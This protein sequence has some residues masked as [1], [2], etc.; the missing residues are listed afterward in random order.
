[1]RTMK[2]GAIRSAEDPDLL[3]I[4]PAGPRAGGAFLLN[5]AVRLGRARKAPGLRSTPR[6]GHSRHPNK[7]RTG[8]PKFPHLE[9]GVLGAFMPPFAERNSAVSAELA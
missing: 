3:A 6:S 1:M 9:A 7:A 2:H 5:D 4:R 8:S